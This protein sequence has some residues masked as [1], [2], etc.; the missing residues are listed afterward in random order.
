MSTMRPL[1]AA[2]GIDLAA[3]FGGLR[4]FGDDGCVTMHQAFGGDM[5]PEEA[6]RRTAAFLR[7]VII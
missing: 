1:D 5:T 2:G 3:I 7:G 4:A 6:T